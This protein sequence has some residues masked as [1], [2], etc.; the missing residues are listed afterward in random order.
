MVLVAALVA[1]VLLSILPWLLERLGAGPET[2]PSQSAS[3]GSPCRRTRRWRSAWGSRAS[4][5]PSGTRAA[6]CTSPSPAPRDG[7][8]RPAP[9]LWPGARDGRRRDH[10]RR[11]A[12]HLRSCRPPWGRQG[13]PA[14][15]RAA[16]RR[17][18]RRCSPDVCDRAAGVLTNVAT[19]VAS[20]FVASVLARFGDE[21]VAAIAIID[22]LVPVAFGGVFAIS[23]A[24]GPILAQNW[25]AGRFDRMR[26][27]AA[28][29][30]AADRRLHR[31]GVA[32]S[33][34]G[35]GRR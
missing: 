6:P 26:G 25:G 1:A 19:P 16:P 32:G 9:H 23:G 17:R 8:A 35:A 11:L 7:R 30:R 18:R 2:L 4:C 10:D 15:R 13:A 14:G 24:V 34:P 5:A 20:G 22:R 27:R 33:D 29:R 21:T 31:R 12:P 3:Y 28:G